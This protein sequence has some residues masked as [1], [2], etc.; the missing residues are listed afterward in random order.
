MFQL[1]EYAHFERV[2]ERGEKRISLT[3]AFCFSGLA[4][5]SRSLRP[6]ERFDRCFQD[7]QESAG[8]FSNDSR[9]D[10]CLGAPT[11]W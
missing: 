6:L 11:V 7:L 4:S 10:S 9:N 2:S 3:H 1:D 5:D 8:D